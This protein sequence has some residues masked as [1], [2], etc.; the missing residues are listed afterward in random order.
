MMSAWVINTR[1]WQHGLLLVAA[2]LLLS[3]CSFQLRGDYQ[4]T[5]QL[6]NLSLEAPTRSEIEKQ[7]QETFAQ[8]DINVVAQGEGITHVVVH[9]DRLDRRILSMLPSGQVAEYEIIYVMPVT[10]TTQSGQTSSHNIQILRDYQDDPNYALAKTRELEMLVGEMRAEA[11][12][13]LLLL[14]NQLTID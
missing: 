1:K 11:A 12:N 3:A 14:L 13:R 9:E 2:M 6:E 10:I 8:R 7:V 4:V 5:S